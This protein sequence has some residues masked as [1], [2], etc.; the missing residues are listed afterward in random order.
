MPVRKNDVSGITV[1]YANITAVLQNCFQISS[2]YLFR[3]ILFIYIIL[4]KLYYNTFNKLKKSEKNPSSEQLN[5][6]KVSRTKYLKF[7]FPINLSIP[8]SHLYKF[9]FKK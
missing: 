1:Y 7:T 8:Y 5:D 4:Q 2:N 6:I 3:L 9:Q